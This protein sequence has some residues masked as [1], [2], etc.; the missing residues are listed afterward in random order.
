[1]RPGTL[2][3]IVSVTSAAG[4]VDHPTALVPLP[5]APLMARAQPSTPIAVTV[6]DAGAQGPY[7][8]R[9]DGLGEYT[10]GA[11]GMTSE[12]D[13]YGSL[14]ITPSNLRLTTPPERTL[15]FD[16]GAP[17]DS[18]NPYRPAGDAQINFKIK[19]NPADSPRIQDLGIDGNPVSWCYTTTMTFATATTHHRVIFST[20]VHPE[21][22]YAYITRTTI[23][24]AEWTMV[25][26]GPCAG[27]A[28][29]AGVSSQDLVKKNAPLVF[30]GYYSL[31][32]SIRFRAL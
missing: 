14:Q 23:L 31:E 26:N 12:I 19:T 3:L 10:H 28:N 22:T 30:R 1:M 7:R 18:L 4:C 17:T 32:F 25:S 29:W 8:I 11:R 24:P 2:A 13:Q 21:A 5:T 9:S 6:E 20:V 15:I 16:L 27:N